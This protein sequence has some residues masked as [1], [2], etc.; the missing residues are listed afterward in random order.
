[1]LQ[2]GQILAARYVLLRRLADG[3]AT[4][5]WHAR[6]RESGGDRVLKILATDA[7]AERAAFIAAAR[8]QQQ[9]T[10]PNLQGCEALH[11]GEPTFAVLGP[12]ARDDLAALRGRPWSQLV[13]VLAA[14]A[15]ALAALHQ[16]GVVHRDLKPANVLIGDDG[17]PLLADFGL[18]ATAGDASAPHG[19]SP[20][21]MSPQQLDGSPPAPADDLYG[22]G[23]LAYELL[24]GYP[25]FYPD[26]RA[27]R[28][29]SEPAATLPA[30]L[31]VPPALEQ[32]VLR[33]L[34]K[35][36]RQR[37]A[38]A[39]AVAAELRVLAAVPAPAG[40]AGTASI[41]LSPP[42]PTGAAIDPQWS[43][44]TTPG[45]T[46]QQWRSQGFRRGL[47]AA[48]MAFLLLAAAFVFFV[49][50][51]QVAQRTAPPPESTPAAVPAAQP[52][53][54]TQ[55]LQQ[56]AE[57]KRAFEELR[58]AVAARLAALEA[59]AA[60][61]WGGATFARGKRAFGDADA[62]FGARKYAA[63][64]TAL[65]AADGDLATTEREAAVQMRSA[66]AEGAAALDGG[67]AAIARRRF[68]RALAIEPGNAAA[69]R[70]IERAGTLDEVRRLL[71]E[72]A[73]LEE[74]G[75]AAAAATAYRK[76]LALD[77]DTQ[78]ARTA[79]ARLEAQASGD[80]FAAA[81]SQGLASLARRDPEAA[82]AAFERAGRL[83]PGSPEVSD[84]LAQVERAL[85]SR[86]I[87]THLVAAQEAERAER[88]SQALVGYRK[89][90][91]VDRNL[92]AARQGVER[93]EPR[94]ML[95]AE[96]EAVIERPERLFS[97]EVRGAARATLQRARG[98][99]APGPVLTR[100]VETV[101]RLVAAAETPLRVALDSDNVTDVTIHRV[102]RLGS[103]ERKDVELLPGRYTV[104]GVRAGFRDVRREITLVPGREAPTV[105]IR[106]EEPI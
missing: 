1:M 49:L 59:R 13:P 86:S 42:P 98:V 55:D 79:L 56:L 104:V 106:C 9:F 99:P 10:H 76:A 21:S 19:G 68:E 80:A 3:R 31:G 30:R 50:P 93:A 35:Q 63:A 24:S 100:Q 37:P 16:R 75:Q 102:G 90:L 5:V 77:R 61:D 32:L 103:F 33:C 81:I 105:V 12:L 34:A 82:R 22:F 15:D 20:F 64:L 91:D 51:S 29:R 25:P 18:A 85:A 72:A 6:D 43:R 41:T 14:I 92:L 87:T 45:P 78:T 84:G 38:D 70:G 40:A 39:A 54:A 48:S 60:G 57:A 67:D 88:W 27:Q 101:E 97:S 69:K 83:R 17:A 73:L 95:D 53:A 2:G 65:R 58:P 62:A 46:P 7:A 23:A 28:V 36:P 47:V 94:A 96:L 66:L 71:A 44:A 11:D 4:Q 52:A 89:A 26:A 8:L 74:Q